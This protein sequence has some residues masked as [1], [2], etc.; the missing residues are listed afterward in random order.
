MVRRHAFDVELIEENARE[1]GS[2]P[3][4]NRGLFSRS[5]GDLV[6]IVILHGS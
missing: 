1:A 3:G 6:E 2:E 5:I 4:D